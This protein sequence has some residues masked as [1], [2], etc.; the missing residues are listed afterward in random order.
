M[1]EFGWW[2]KTRKC[3]RENREALRVEYKL[4]VK[5]WLL[6]EGLGCKSN[7]GKKI[8]SILA[9]ENKFKLISVVAIKF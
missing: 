9:S 8:S 3:V 4:I 5:Q 7:G 6:N 2:Q 1:Q